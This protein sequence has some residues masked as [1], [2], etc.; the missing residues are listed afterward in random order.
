[1][2]G[3]VLDN[4]AENILDIFPVPIVHNLEVLK[5]VNTNMIPQGRKSQQT[6]AIRLSM[7]KLNHQKRHLFVCLFFS[8]IYF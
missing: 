3:L 6:L 8:F 1:M 4:I 5:I 2:L 7:S